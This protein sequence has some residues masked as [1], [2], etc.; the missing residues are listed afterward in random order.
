MKIRAPA[1]AKATAGKHH[2]MVLLALG[3]IFVVLLLAKFLIPLLRFG[4]VPLGYDAGIYRYLFIQ[5]QEALSH[6]TMPDLPDFAREHPLGLFLLSTPILSLG[7]PVDWLTGWIWNLFVPLVGML[8]AW[9]TGR[10]CGWKVGVWTLLCV[11]LSHAFYDGFTAMYWKTYVALFWMV[12]TFY[13]IEQKSWWGVVTGAWTLVS[14]HQ[15]GLLFV[16][17]LGTW[18]LLNIYKKAFSLQLSAFSICIMGIAFVFVG[19]LYLPIFQE[20]VL[21]HIPTLFQLWKAPG[22]SFPEPLFYT[23]ITGILLLLGAAGFLKSLEKEQWTLWQLAVL[24]SGVFVL[25]RL[26]FYR[27]FMLQLDFFLLPFSA[28]FIVF[29]WERYRSIGGRLSLIVVL[30]VQGVLSVQAALQRLPKVDAATFS[31]VRSLPSGLPH[32]ATVIA[33]EDQSAVLLRG[34]LPFH[35]VGGPGLF[36]LSWSYEEWEKFLLGSP[37]ERRPYFERLEDPTFFFISPYFRSYYSEHAE[38][39]LRDPCLQ[40]T[41]HPYLIRSVCSK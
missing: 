29:L 2:D 27:R 33:L 5:Y 7:V 15:T 6:F 39:F 4:S 30:I 12:L 31:V 18:G 17:V 36:E 22:G 23:R 41:E 16:L 11:F 19:L 1:F 13:F 8:L 21:R 25:F 20:S 40:R 9:V 34:W 35:R 3:S 10:R 32:D 38:A 28:S 24:W 26:M 14:H 37:K